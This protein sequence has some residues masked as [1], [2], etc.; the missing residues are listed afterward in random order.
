MKNQFRLRQLNISFWII[1]AIVSS[2]CSNL[3]LGHVNPE[4][5]PP[6]QKVQHSPLV[7]STDLNTSSNLRIVMASTD[8]AV[9]ENRLT[10][11]ILD[12]TVRH[13]RQPQT[14]VLAFHT[15]SELHRP[16]TTAIGNFVTWPNGRTGVYVAILN[17]DLPG[18][19]GVIV[20]IQGQNGTPT[21]IQSEIFEVKHKSSSPPIGESAPASITKTLST[22]ATI[23][24][25]TTSP[26]PDPDLYRIT[27]AQAINSRIPTVLTFATP[28][29]CQTATCG[30]QVN[31][32]SSLKSRFAP[33]ANFIHV[34]VYENSQEYAGDLSKLRLV[35]A[36]SE[37]G[38]LTE[39]FTFVIDKNGLIAAKFEGFVTERELET[40][41]RSTMEKP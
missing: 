41:L 16:R 40:A 27:I 35:P 25:L 2:G 38:L 32:L 9:G 26:N 31:V 34:E 10:F 5:K 28:A 6:S 21:R 22:V 11:G 20:E 37:W 14:T 15:D 17:L 29:F 18:N 3:T 24:E 4:T 33:N 1:V 36:M 8:F 23:S 12:G 7:T 39:P 30:P 19:W 13:I